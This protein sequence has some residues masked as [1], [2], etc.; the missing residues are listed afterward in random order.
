MSFV[1]FVFKTKI[2]HF[3]Q[4]LLISKA[5]AGHC[6]EMCAQFKSVI[7][8]HG[9]ILLESM[10][11]WHD[12]LTIIL[13]NVGFQTT[14]AASFINTEMGSELAFQSNW[15]NI[16]SPKPKNTSKGG[17]RY[18]LGPKGLQ[19]KNFC[20]ICLNHCIIQLV[21]SDRLKSIVYNLDKHKNKEKCCNTPR[22]SVLTH[23]C[24]FER[25]VRTSAC[26]VQWILKVFTEI[27]TLKNKL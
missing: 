3:L 2:F 12:I 26:M 5:T 16:S 14:G 24:T 27:T 10:E 4:V 9:P 13:S 8:H 25:L 6:S 21:R 15:I 20:Q 22:Q 23:I 7:R 1:Q 18:C 11:Y 19:C 17:C